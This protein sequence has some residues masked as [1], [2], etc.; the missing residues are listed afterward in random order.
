MTG[1]AKFSS[2]QCLIKCVG[3]GTK[4]IYYSHDLISIS[5]QKVAPTFCLQNRI[6][7]D[8]LAIAI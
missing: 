5:D 1:L 8:E 7:Y 6:L 4:I 3:L 2:E